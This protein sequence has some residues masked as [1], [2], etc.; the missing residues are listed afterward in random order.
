MAQV[1]EA[2]LIVVHL[3]VRQVTVAPLVADLVAVTQGRV[4]VRRPVDLE[5]VVTVVQVAADQER[6]AVPRPVDLE[7]EDMVAR[8]LVPPVQA[9]HLR[10]A[11]GMVQ[12]LAIILAGLACQE[13]GRPA[14][15]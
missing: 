4:E 12:R 2:D 14:S 11:R 10:M 7:V 13:W 1:L 3:W 15:V 5:T 8:L 9:P 6:V